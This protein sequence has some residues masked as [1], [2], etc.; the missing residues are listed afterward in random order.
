[1]SEQ[2]FAGGLIRSPEDSR[3]HV[4]SLDY[5]G[6]P[7]VPL[8]IYFSWA[9]KPNHPHVRDQGTRG[10][11]A[12]FAGATVKSF[13]DRIE[14]GLTWQLSPEWVYG[15]AK[16]CDGLPT[17]IE[18]T[19]PRA[20]FK[21]MQSFGCCQEIYWPY[22]QVWPFPL[23][24]AFLDAR[25]HRVESY[26][27]IDHTDHDLVK[28][29]LIQKGPL[30]S[31]V[32]VTSNWLRDIENIWLIGLTGAGGEEGGHAITVVGWCPDG[33]IIQNS[34]SEKWGRFGYACLTWRWWDTHVWELWKSVDKKTKGRPA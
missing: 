15:F 19:Y 12:G 14:T 26:G 18:G 20:I 8:P 27:V 23:P 3:D 13:Q 4:L 22:N 29:I 34:W 21:V 33:F 5:F 25:N 7:S 1:M 28:Q 2:V 10:T 30:L 32:G 16:Q 17:G 31:G 11:C 24:G 9:D 6:L